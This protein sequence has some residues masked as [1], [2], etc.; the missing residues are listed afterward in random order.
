[1][2]YN[3]QFYAIWI[4]FN[5]LKLKIA[6]KSTQGS[7]AMIWGKTVYF[8]REDWSVLHREAKTQQ[9]RRSSICGSKD[10]ATVH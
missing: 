9:V 3:G 5:F 10:N 4:Y 6:Y 1:M 8:H 2:R 7:I